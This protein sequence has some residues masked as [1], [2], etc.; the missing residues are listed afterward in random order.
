MI[1]T[2]VCLFVCFEGEGRRID[3]DGV[4]TKVVTSQPTQPQLFKPAGSC[5]C[6]V[7]LT[8]G[9]LVVGSIEL[10]RY[11]SVSEILRDTPSAL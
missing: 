2:V 7:A 10:V 4:P 9:I 3:E 1:Q 5:R 8:A 6:V 11:S